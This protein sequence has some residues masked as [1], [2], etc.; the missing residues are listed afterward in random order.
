MDYNI[1]VLDSPM[2]Y[3]KTTSLINMMNNKQ[4]RAYIFITP[5]L[6]EVQRIKNSCPTLNFKEPKTINGSKLNG[7]K[8]LI[9]NGDNIVSTHALFNRADKELIDL[10]NMSGYTLILDEV[11][12][13]VDKADITKDDINLVISQQLVTVEDSGLVR[14]NN[15]KYKGRFS[16]IMQYC[17]NESIY[18]MNETFV[19]WTLPVT[20]FES[21]KEVWI[22]TY[23]FDWQIQKYYYDF[24]GVEYE[25]YHIKLNEDGTREMVK[26][27]GS[28]SYEKDFI[29]NV[30]NLLHICDIDKLNSIGDPIKTKKNTYSNTALSKTWYDELEKKN[31]RV[32]GQ[33]NKISNNIHNYFQNICHA[34]SSDVL[35]TTFKEYEP[36]LK[37]KGYAKAFIP[38]N[39]RATNDYGDRHYMAYC[40]NRFMM[41]W[42]VQFFAQRGVEVNQDLWALS[43]MLQWIWRSAI[44]NGEEVYIYIPSNRMRE[45]LIKWM[46]E[47]LYKF[48]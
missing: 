9:T 13:V 38:M 21:F 31:K 27:E 34:K 22:S 46:N 48:E 28:F 1:K 16:D 29:A 10:L 7:L 4:D 37:G 35:W 43:E 33:F 12:N 45:L 40:C 30:K 36:D 26:T 18:Y 19:V 20:I 47:E 6:T 39:S 11:A 5:F 23:Q 42:Q 17:Y 44:R 14:W 41:P 15:E 2:G 8:K 32:S 3:G 24:F 25:Y